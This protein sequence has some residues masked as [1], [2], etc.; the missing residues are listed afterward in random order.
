MTQSSTSIEEHLDFF[1][2]SENSY[3]IINE[4]T[5][6]IL[7]YKDSLGDLTRVRFVDKEGDLSNIVIFPYKGAAE[8]FIKN[9]PQGDYSISDLEQVYKGE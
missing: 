5:K 1:I 2:D 3:A 4:S 6:E 7:S 8:E 9:L